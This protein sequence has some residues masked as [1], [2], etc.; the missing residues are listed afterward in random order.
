MAL[1][2]TPRGFYKLFDRPPAI[3]GQLWIFSIFLATLHGGPEN[4]PKSN[5][6]GAF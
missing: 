5:P 3:A 1:K 6:N 2:K 4:G